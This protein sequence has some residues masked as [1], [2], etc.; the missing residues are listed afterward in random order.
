MKRNFKF[1]ALT[2]AIFLVLFNTIVFL[3]R[4]I[5]SGYVINYDARFWIAWLFVMV[6]FA[7][8]LLCANWAFRAE[9]LER[10]FYKVPL[11]TVS[12]IGLIVMLVL[13]GLLM[14]I[15]NCPAWIAAV[16]CVAVAA[17]TAVAIVKADWAGEAVSVVHEKTKVQ[18]QFIKLLT[19]DAETLLSKTKNLN[20]KDKAAAQKVYEALRY[21][22]PMSSESLGGIEIELAEKFKSFETAVNTEMDVTVAAESLLETLEKRNRLCKL[23]K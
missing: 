7:G 12:Y 19:V 4:T 14:L 6:A 11:I 9:N 1:Y 22:D 21:S 18:T 13:G 20:D 2:W 16:V 15:P 10:L 17:F 5:I 3:I 23:N 8:N